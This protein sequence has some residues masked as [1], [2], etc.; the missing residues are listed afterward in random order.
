MLPSGLP[1]ESARR[2][3]IVVVDTDVVSF[4]FKRD[5]RAELYRRHLEGRRPLISAQT[6]AELHH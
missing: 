1:A 3:L 4:L 5:T 6:L 2:E